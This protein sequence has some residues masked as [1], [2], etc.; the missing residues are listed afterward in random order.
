M[1]R[2]TF[3]SIIVFC[4]AAMMVGGCSKKLEENPRTFISPNSFFTSADSYELT[5]IGIY[6]GIPSTFSSNAWLTRETFSDIIGTP[7]ATYEGGLSVYLNNHQPFFYS[8]REPWTSYY[9][10]IKNANFI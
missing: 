2:V 1:K 9:S 4:L 7:S 5:V 3:K 10:I 8:V 6:S